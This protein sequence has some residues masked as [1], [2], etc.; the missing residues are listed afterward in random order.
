M[1][2]KQRQDLNTGWK[3]RLANAN[4]EA[5]ADE[6]LKSWTP[7]Q[8]F[9]SVIQMELLAHKIIPDPNVGENER[10]I[11]WAGRAD[12][13]YSCTFPTPEGST[14]NDL[15]LEGLDTFATVTLNGREILKSDNMF[16]PHRVEVTS[17]LK[18]VKQ[19]N[20]LSIV[21]ES[22]WKKGTELEAKF[23]PRKTWM[24]DRRRMHTR[25]AQYHFGWDWGP[26]VLTSGPYMPVY[27]ETYSARIDNV[28]VTSDL[29]EDHSTAT[30]SIAVTAAGPS[31]KTVRVKILDSASSAVC[32]NLD[33]PLDES[34]NGSA[35][36]EIRNPQLWWPNGQGAQHLYTLS[37]SLLDESSSELDSSTTR[38]GIRTIKVIQRP[39]D[40]APGKTFMFNVNGRDIFAQGGNWIPTDMLLPTVTRER[41]FSWI[42]L[43]KLHHLNMIRVWGGGIYETDDFL[44]ACDEMGLLVWHDYALA[45]GDYPVY[46][47]F[48]DSMQAEA[49][50]QTVR[51]R[52]HASL[53]LLCGSNE[54][55]MFFDFFGSPYDFSDHDGP[56]PDDG[57]FPQRKIYLQL[58]PDV[59]K[60]LCPEI[61]YWPSSPWGDSGAGRSN[62]VTVGDI[63]QWEVWHGEQKP[64]QE[65]GAL[66]GRF[67]SEFGM[68]G[69]PIMR[70]VD[71]FAPEPKDRFPQSR[72]IDCHNKGHGA[73]TRIA[74]YMAQNF[75]YDMD[76]ENYIYCSYL[77][78]SEALGYA[79]R[80][81]KRK[82][83]GKGK[84]ECAGALIWQFNDVY[85]CTSWAYV[86][87][88]LRPKPAFYSIRRNFAPIS[89]GL[90]R[91]P[92]TRWIDEDNPR[93]SEIPRFTVFAHNTTAQEVQCA[94]QLKA[95]DFYTGAWTEVNLE[96]IASE[97]VL[98][99]GQNTEL[100]AVSPHPSW[101][102]D[103]LIILEASLLDTTTG[104]VLARFVD[105]PEPYR[106]LLWPADTTVTISVEGVAGNQNS[107]AAADGDDDQ[108]E[109]LVTVVANR[110]V[111]GCWLEPVYDGT[112][113][114]DEPEPFWEDNMF[115]LLPGQEFK[116]GVNG[117]RGRK[118]KARFLGDWE[119]KN[120]IVAK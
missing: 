107:G 67:V 63:H 112:E 83:G 3:W 6:S 64:Y 9:P 31:A 1:A 18:P 59:C 82:F 87:Y 84:E 65:Y 15:V 35:T 26:T 95:Y 118:V 72:V 24:R 78:Q 50:A 29:A 54:D 44:D 119:V 104:K 43:A 90:E 113:T 73:E 16:I 40:N 56:F 33:I 85:P 80:D 52:N 11:Q 74:R 111:K 89:V 19:D 27:L 120:P 21:F 23:G 47:D 46:Q 76:F 102:E 75:R 86:D 38:F 12:W 37:A 58:L 34:K 8:S 53:A 109:H 68:H 96:G 57:P 61:Q 103:S 25:K 45:C 2:I 69:F 93:D 41:Y 108:F 55:F 98:L 66:S 20:E 32:S 77:L 14:F 79:L 71:V 7:V 101:T 88:F 48:L 62:D 22:A 17:F 60:K 10:Q 99:A 30:V 105:W 70:T 5:K 91:T 110:P 100:G 36:V 94:L 117:L 49:E 106:Y 39:L 114:E 4:G 92:N 13:E 28:H 42:R 116:V 115:D 51:M 81:W 97:A